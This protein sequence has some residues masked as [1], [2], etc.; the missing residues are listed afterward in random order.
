M[1]S[2]FSVTCSSSIEAISGLLFAFYYVMFF[3][4]HVVAVPMV[5]LGLYAWSAPRIPRAARASLAAW[6]V[7]PKM[8]VYSA[9]KAFDLVL[10]ERGVVRRQHDVPALRQLLAEVHARGIAY[11]DDEVPLGRDRCLMEPMVLAR[12]LQAA[13]VLIGRGGK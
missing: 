10:A 2:R 1:G 6:M 9:T 4:L 13:A 7:T 12:L 5:L 11:V 8:G 3:A